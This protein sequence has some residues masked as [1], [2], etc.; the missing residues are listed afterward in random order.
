M[1]SAKYYEKRPSNKATNS[2][3]TS[4]FVKKISNYD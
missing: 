2:K 1:C 3:K 4:Y